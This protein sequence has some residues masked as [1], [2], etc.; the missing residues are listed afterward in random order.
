M[1]AIGQPGALPPQ[2]D[3]EKLGDDPAKAADQNSS[4]PRRLARRS[5]GSAR[6]TQSR[7]TSA[8]ATMLH[9]GKYPASRS[10]RPR[11]RP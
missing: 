7:R 6:G 10:M 9:S 2:R 4:R 3:L 5:E 8:N 1:G 11:P